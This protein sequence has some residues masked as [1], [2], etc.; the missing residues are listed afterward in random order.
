M[1][2]KDVKPLHNLVAIKEL[3]EADSV[4]HMPSSANISNKRFV[5][6]AAGPGRIGETGH[7]VGAHLSPGDVVIFGSGQLLKVRCDDGDV[8]LI[9]DDSMCAIVGQVDV[10]TFLERAQAKRLAELRS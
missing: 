10:D 4:I 7:L 9:S 6:I 2:I 8:H 3:V 1:R 5:V